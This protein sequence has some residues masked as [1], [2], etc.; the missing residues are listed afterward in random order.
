MKQTEKSTEMKDIDELLSLLED[1]QNDEKEREKES[2]IINPFNRLNERRKSV[3]IHSTEG[4]ILRRK[5]SRFY[6]SFIEK[7]KHQI[8]STIIESECEVEEY[9]EIDYI[10]LCN[11]ERII[12]DEIE[13]VS[14]FI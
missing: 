4:V 5:S 2:E 14:H 13:R 9:T 11:E 10:N 3:E 12:T 6:E 1:S 8:E 7:N